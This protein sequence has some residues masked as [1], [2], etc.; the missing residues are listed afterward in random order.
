[1]GGSLHICLSRICGTRWS[2]M[3]WPLQRAPMPGA[4]ILWYWMASSGRG[5][6]SASGSQWT[7]LF[8]TSCCVLISAPLSLARSNALATV[9]RTLVRFAIC[10]NNLLISAT[11]GACDRYNRAIS[12]C[13]AE[14]C[15]RN[16]RD[17]EGPDSGQ[18]SAGQLQHNPFAIIHRQYRTSA[19][20]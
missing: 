15:P 8:I 7:F 1:M 14:S 9:S 4:D 3:L 12:C 19:L 11:L 5:F 17:R 6:W 13:Y 18:M 2:S 20:P 16:D 10:T